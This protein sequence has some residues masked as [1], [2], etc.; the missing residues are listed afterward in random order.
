MC[1]CACVY[2]C[3]HTHM[4][5]LCMCVLVHACLQLGLYMCVLV[6]LEEAEMLVTP[7][8][9]CLEGMSFWD[10]N[11]GPLQEYTCS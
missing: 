6:S 2:L 7:E 4:C 10:S 5:I 1:M 11:S 9:G 8:Q 3:M